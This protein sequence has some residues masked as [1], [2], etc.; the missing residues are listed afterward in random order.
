MWG[1]R[2]PKLLMK[3]TLADRPWAAT[4]NSIA[5]AGH[6]GQL[7][8]KSDGKIYQV[9]FA[10]GVVVGATSPCPADTVQRIGLTNLGLPAAS[11]AAAVR[12][13]GRGDDVDKFTEAA[14]LVNNAAVDFKQRVLIQRVARTFTCERGE[15]VLEDK[16]TIPVLQR[17]VVDVRAAI[18]HG[19]R[20]HVPEIKLVAEL[21][22][23]GAS[24]ILYP[25][26]APH[27][28][29]F[30]LG[31]EAEV[32]LSE[33]RG[34]TSV[35]ELEALHRDLDPRLVLAVLTALATC[36]VIMPIEAR[37]RTAQD[38]SIQRAPTPRSP[39]ISRVPTPRQP[40]TSTSVP[41]DVRH[42]APTN[43]YPLAAG[44]QPRIS[45]TQTAD[46]DSDRTMTITASQIRQLIASRVAMLECGVDFFSFLGI[47][48][49]APAEHVR[50]AYLELARYLRPER[51]AELR[52]G[53]ERNEARTVFA[54]ALIAMTTL[55]D[56][57]RRA[58][59]MAAVH[60]RARA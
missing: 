38:I 5:V 50:A 52:I 7:T 34:V 55:T 57:R 36:N 53:D 11:I 43:K 25:E 31:A 28:E 8:L 4:L 59:Y 54:Q 21:R 45:R 15:F 26:A 32:I 56:E 33:L 18:Y 10:N 16:V 30:D 24:F 39:T 14:G 22:Q 1:S 13:L 35:P 27:L 40:T 49:G 12:I 41:V 51:L 46:F 3:G 6:S 17:V 42:E 19:M 2:K 29:K 48:F 47:P 20:M 44:S 23:L 9:A 60:G 58:E 37:V